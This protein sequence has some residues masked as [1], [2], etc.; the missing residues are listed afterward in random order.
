MD[1]T[2]VINDSIVESDEETND[3]KTKEGRQPLA[4][5][6]ILKNDHVPEREFPLFVGDNILGRDVST[7]TLPLL[8][9]SISKQH[10]TICIS[11]HRRRG[12]RRG[13]DMEALVWDL[14]SMNGTRKG[15]LKLTPNV[16]YA[17]SEG[18]HLVMAD[19]PCQYVNISDAREDVGDRTSGVRVSIPGDSVEKTDCVKASTSRKS[20]ASTTV[21]SVGAAEK[22]LVQNSCVSFESTPVQML[23]TLVPESDSDSE[24][25]RSGLREV[26]C[27]LIGSHSDSHVSSP[28]CSTFLSP[29]S[30]IV[31]ESPYCEDE[32]PVLP[33]TSTKETPHGHVSFSKEKP[34][35]DVGGQQ[36]K[37]TLS[38]ADD[39]D[40][41]GA[42]EIGQTT[43]KATLKES[44]RIV[45][46]QLKSQVCFT[47]EKLLQMSTSTV[48]THAVPKFNMDSDT[49]VDSDE[50]EPVLDQKPN[51]ACFHM[52]SDTDVDDENDA[53][54]GDAASSSLQPKAGDGVRDSDMSPDAKIADTVTPVLPDDFQLDSDTDVDEEAD[55][56]SR[57]ETPSKLNLIR[58]VSE[59]DED[60]TTNFTT[61]PNVRD[62]TTGSNNSNAA[63]E[64][65]QFSPVATAPSSVPCGVVT[66]AAQLDYE[67]CVPP[68]DQDSDTDV[69]EEK[70]PI[71]GVKKSG[72]EASHL[73]N[74]STPVQLSGQM[75]EMETQAF[76]SPSLDPGKGAVNSAAGSAVLSSHLDSSDEEDIVVAETQYFDNQTQMQI[77]SGFNNSHES[78]GKDL[79]ELP[80]TGAS[81]QLGLS[82]SSHLQS[83]A[84][85]LARENTQAFAMVAEAE[86]QMFSNFSSAETASLGNGLNIE[87]VQAYV[88]PTRSPG[89]SERG[90]QLNLALQETQAYVSD[91]DSESE[92]PFD[93]PQ[94]PAIDYP[95]GNSPLTPLQPNQIAKA[96]DLSEEYGEVS[97]SE[98]GKLQLDEKMQPVTNS[99]GL[100]NLQPISIAA[101]Q[102]MAISGTDESSDEDFSSVLH[103]GKAQLNKE[104]QPN[105]ISRGLASN[106]QP[107]SVGAT[108]P[109]TTSENKATDSK[110]LI[111]VS[112]E[113]KMQR[114]KGKQ[115]NL[116]MTIAATQP[117]P[118]SENEESND[119]DL[120][121]AT[122]SK[123][124]IQVSCESK[125]QR[126]KGKQATFPMTIAATQP[127]PTSE[128]EESDDEDL[129]K[130]MAQPN[131]SLFDLASNHHSIAATQAMATSENEETDSED[132]IQVLGKGKVQLDNEMQPS[133]SSVILAVTAHPHSIAESQPMATIQNESDEE[134]SVPLLRNR[135]KARQLEE[136]QSLSSTLEIPSGS[137]TC[138]SPAKD[139]VES[140]EN[141]NEPPTAETLIQPTEEKTW[142]KLDNMANNDENQSGHGQEEQ[143]TQ[144][145]VN[146][147]VSSAAIQVKDSCEDAED[148]SEIIIRS[149]RKRKA[150][151]LQIEETQS[152][153]GSQ[154]EERVC[155][156]TNSETSVVER[157]SPST[158]QP[159]PKTIKLGSEIG[160]SINERSRRKPSQLREKGEPLEKRQT[161]GNKARG[162][163]RMSKSAGS[164]SE[165]EAT[166]QQTILLEVQDGD[167]RQ[168][169]EIADSARKEETEQSETVEEGE[170]LERPEMK[171][172]RQ[173]T[174]GSEAE[175]QQNN[176][177]Q[178]QVPQRGR[179]GTR[180]T[181]AVPLTADSD[182]VPAKRTRSRSNSSN[183][184]SSEVSTS[185]TQGGRGREQDNSLDS[186][187]GSLSRS[188]SSNSLASEMSCGSSQ[189]GRGGKQRGRGRKTEPGPSL[190]QSTLIQNTAPK[191]TPSGKRGRKA[192]ISTT[193]LSDE[194]VTKPESK[195]VVA[196][197]GRRRAN[198]EQ[199]S[200]LAN[201]TT[202]D[203]PPPKRNIRGRLQRTEKSEVL[204]VPVAPMGSNIVQ[205][206][207]KREGRKRMLEVEVKDENPSAVQDKRKTRASHAEGGRNAKESPH[208]TASE[209][210]SVT[211]VDDSGEGAQVLFTGVVDQAGEKVVTRLGGVLANGTADMNCLVTD[212]VRRTV[213]FLCAVAK[214]IP[215]VNTQW[216]DK[217]GK[218]G[219]FLPP[220]AFIVNDPE[221]EQKFN[222]CLQETLRL[223]SREPLLQG[224]KIHITKSVKPEPV[225]MKDIISCCGA[226]F[227]P[228]MPSTHKPYTLVVSCTEDWSLCRRAVSASLPIVTA[229]FILSGILQHKVDFD[230]H[231]LSGPFDP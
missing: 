206:K 171:A 172:K 37:N 161:R 30:K 59:S 115:A 198:V 177:A 50:A 195:Q 110:N 126:H 85:A 101:T 151:P 69:E 54:A 231:K 81:F 48:S 116:P 200:N 65:P 35:M 158:D 176:V 201:N 155:E 212:K 182:D 10:A 109:M 189:R 55:S 117:L 190:I 43:E 41:D 13:V 75:E 8:A 89:I 141:N 193:E 146:S 26:K 103:E 2:Q 188:T 224:Y 34:D 121:K 157:R 74:C 58:D 167:Q 94:N 66:T 68:T 204:E 150:R 32:S 183:S 164:E 98:D 76:L 42:A 31:P 149:S 214:G 102:P 148:D 124:L 207:D 90:R 211:S 226:T 23:G 123:N 229:E 142:P 108:Q 51:A 178:H 46:E 163:T 135:R 147:E 96:T 175:L 145:L 78:S 106:L 191:A 86:T 203:S 19:I 140:Q 223:A 87:T 6:C 88:S 80:V 29:A 131:R 28:I 104:I 20:Q 33:S 122:D 127:L 18:D 125:M 192:E 44:E 91:C 208:N 5:L 77:G 25:E 138:E 210:G 100:A 7:C 143:Q 213:K 225:H 168:E 84:Q 133:T 130:D 24:C 73:Q 119:E 199:P 63:R 38:I 57:D 196:T 139:S 4:K 17:L 52:D 205:A 9:P 83:E 129:I 217:S 105:L 173:K 118:T 62:S 144:T 220:D 194:A 202:G 219:T 222:F 61:H 209:G 132:P 97:V 39:S 70:N 60:Q 159:S 53:A 165:E 136:T 152:L 154:M 230:T 221:Q 107:L 56:T 134:D 45:Q 113:S 114:H 12:S 169:C 128:N 111:Q 180:R 92:E 187:L 99:F 15:R 162:Q 184:V 197:R 112:C 49:D 185:S 160:T 216:L 11:V 72:L 14:G 71:E 156:I 67:S 93:L 1:A 120:I 47:E 27:K 186:P 179:R 82:D 22:Q 64:L 227:I 174:D 3:E 95:T 137:L 36:K 79:E 215:I 153:I 166:T 16:R 40:E 218:A 228:K 21:S 170:R 181:I